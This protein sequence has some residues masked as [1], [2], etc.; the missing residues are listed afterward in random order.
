MKLDRY[1]LEIALEEAQIAFEEGTIPIG[2][3]LV[4]PDG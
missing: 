2:A 4:S 1:F 3:V